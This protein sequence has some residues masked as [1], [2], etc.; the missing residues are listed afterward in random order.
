MCPLVHVCACVGVCVCVGVS[1]CLYACLDGWVYVCLFVCMFVS[2]C[3]LSLVLPSLLISSG[4][5]FCLTSSLA[6]WLVVCTLPHVEWAFL[7][8][9]MQAFWPVAF[10]LH[11]GT[12][13]HVLLCGC[14]LLFCMVAHGCMCCSVVVLWVVCCA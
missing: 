1:V 14:L 3:P 7:L 13:L 12:W 11:G 9:C 8:S 6:W 10:V 5:P 2:G 4:C